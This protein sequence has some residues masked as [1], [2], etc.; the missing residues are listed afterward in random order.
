MKTYI[1]EMHV[2]VL[3][4]KVPEIVLCPCHGVGSGSEGK[5]LPKLGFTGWKLLYSDTK[6]IKLK[7]ATRWAVTLSSP[8]TW[9]SFRLVPHQTN[10]PFEFTFKSDTHIC[11]GLTHVCTGDM[12]AT[13]EYNIQWAFS[14]KSHRNRLIDACDSERSTQGTSGKMFNK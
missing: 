10:I 1:K 5:T 6:P 12:T 13:W 3:S 9:W 14:L 7:Q 11:S 4:Q 2:S 8:F